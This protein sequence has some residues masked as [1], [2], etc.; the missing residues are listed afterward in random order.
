MLAKAGALYY[1]HRQFKPSLKYFKTLAKQFPQS[2]GA[3]RAR[4]TVMESYFG[5]GDFTSTELI[6]KRLKDA[7][8]EFGEKVTKR[9]AESIFFQ[10]KTYAD[11]SLHFQAAEEYRHVVAEV[12]NA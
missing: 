5:K 3:N 7:A 6:A 9:L 8:P 11:S 2:E 1:N 12:P 10:A 4:F